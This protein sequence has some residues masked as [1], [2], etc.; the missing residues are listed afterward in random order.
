MASVFTIFGENAILAESANKMISDITGRAGVLSKI[1]SKD[2]NTAMAVGKTIAKGDAVGA[3]ARN[4]SAHLFWIFRSLYGK[5]ELQS[6]SSG[7]SLCRWF[8][9]IRLGRQ[10][11]P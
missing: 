5:V 10:R 11:Q 9:H 2:R 6:L 4:P 8:G 3:I 7:S 1:F